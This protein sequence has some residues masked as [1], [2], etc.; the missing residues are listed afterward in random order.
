MKQI[1]ITRKFQYNGITLPDPN[2]RLSTD[3]VRGFY[4]A[5]Y[6]ELNNS[7]VEGPVT[8]GNVSTYTF[9]RA[10]GA[11]GRG[12]EP[13]EHRERLQEVIL[14]PTVDQGLGLTY[15]QPSESMSRALNSLVQVGNSKQTGRALTAPPM[16]YGFWG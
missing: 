4:A 8:K 2:A 11:K 3:D 13:N 16:A 7:V 15:V 5:Q 6:P 14:K 1:E 9:A 10:A 12:V